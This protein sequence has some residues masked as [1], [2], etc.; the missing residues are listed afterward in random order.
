MAT[1]A[2]SAAEVLAT[3]VQYIKGAGP[4]RAELLARLGLQTACDVVFCFPRDY[5]DLTELRNIGDLEEGELQSVAGTVEEVEL[6]PTQP[7]RSILGVLVRQGN[8]YL[9]AIWFN[10]PFMREKFTLGGGVLLSGTA[11]LRGG[12]WEMAHPQVKFLA[13]SVSDAA[14]DV[15]GLIR[16]GARGY[17]TKTISPEQLAEA[18]GTLS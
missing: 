4:Q 7:G 1:R 11:R 15:I 13:L 17:V 14:E 12:R 16:A 2:K 18:G 10:Q 5:Q 3:P 6:R 8:D 9:R